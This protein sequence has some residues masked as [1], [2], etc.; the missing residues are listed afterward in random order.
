MATVAEVVGYAGYK[1]ILFGVECEVEGERLPE[2]LPRG[3]PI[4]VEADG[5]VS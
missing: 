4:R 1:G 5:P 3:L 2:V